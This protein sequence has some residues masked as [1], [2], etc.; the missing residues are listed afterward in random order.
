L[1]EEGVA[2]GGDL[3]KTAHGFMAFAGVGLNLELCLVAMDLAWPF[4]FGHQTP[5]G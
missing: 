4:G 1:V 5:P 3:V 2:A